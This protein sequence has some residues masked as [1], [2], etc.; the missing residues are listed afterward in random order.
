MKKFLMLIIIIN[1][2]ILTGCNNKENISM[3]T[4][5]YLNTSDTVQVNTYNGYKLIESDMTTNEDE[6]IVITLKFNKPI[7]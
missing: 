5:W 4:R 6:T 2:L 7:K 1:A 3:D